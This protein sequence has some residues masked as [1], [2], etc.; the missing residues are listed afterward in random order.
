MNANR[1]V[2]EGL[3]WFS[4]PALHDNHQAALISHFKWFAPRFKESL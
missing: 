1:S 2:F 4:L 3:K